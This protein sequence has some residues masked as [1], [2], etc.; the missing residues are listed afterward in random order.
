MERLYT[1]MCRKI[2][3][4]NL[5]RSV[6][7]LHLQGHAHKNRELEGGFVF[8]N[9]GKRRKRGD[10]RK[11]RE[12]PC[13]KTTVIATTILPEKEKA[14]NLSFAGKELVFT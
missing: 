5:R 6:F 4:R 7:S 13:K 9:S 10:F 11:E 3:H 14:K 1:M 2:C 12:H 8:L